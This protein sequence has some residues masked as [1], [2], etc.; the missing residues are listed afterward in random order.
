M[1]TADGTRGDARR[2]NAVVSA[3]GQLNRPSFPDIPGRDTFAGPSF[4]SATLGPLGRP[5]RQARRGDR[6]RRERGAVHP[7]DRARRSASCSCSSARRRGSARRPTTTTRSRRAA[8]ALRPRAVVQRV[9]PL[10]DLLAD[11]RRRAR[12]ACA[13]TRRGSRRGRSV[14]RGQRPRAHDAHAATSA[15][16]SPTGPTCSK[17]RA[18]L[19]ARRE[20]HA[21]RQRRL[22]AHAQARQRAA[23]SPT[24]IREITPNGHRHRRRRRSTRST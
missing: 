9:E 1:R 11:G 7:R 22:G 12:R 16:S 18:D 4:H 6:H 2:R 8:L 13:S 20:A 23:R 24:P 10:L 19:P 15:P 3:V 17:R 5:R 21:P 14:E